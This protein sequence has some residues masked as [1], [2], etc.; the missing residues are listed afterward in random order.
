ME[1]S[2]DEELGVHQRIILKFQQYFYTGY[3]IYVQF[4]LQV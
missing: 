3:K 4:M 2:E 1:N